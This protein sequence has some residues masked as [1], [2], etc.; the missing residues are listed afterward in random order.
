MAGACGSPLRSRCA[1]E[2]LSSAITRAI[3]DPLGA[4]RR[5]ADRFTGRT[6][7]PRDATDAF[8]TLSRKSRQLGITGIN[9]AFSFD[10]DT[11]EDAAASR[12]VFAELRRRGVPAT[13]AV[14]GATLEGAA[15]QYRRL[16]A[17]GARFMN[18]GHRPHAEL[19]D[20][21]YYGITFYEELSTDDV[22]RD[23]RAGH[24]SVSE[25]IGTPP[26]GFRGPHFGSFQK[27]EN[28]QLVYGVARELGYA[29]CSDTLPQR[30]YDSGPVFDVGGG[31][32]ESPLTGSLGDPLVILDS[33]NYLAD[34]TQYRLQEQYATRFAE[35]GDFFATRRLPALLNYYADPAHVVADGIFLRAIDHALAAGA[36][37]HS[38]EDVLQ[39]TRGR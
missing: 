39:M 30:A 31:L 22:V 37:F 27:P 20:G 10:C 33:W 1:G 35:T 36:R 23:I 2:S 7:A 28:R 17:D 6:D 18:H 24:R 26:R 9:V 19:R 8:E 34:R 13:F 5:V 14:P 12:Q 25:V 15:D 11:P 16:A 3:R 38:F 29:F 32:K 4:L 21:R